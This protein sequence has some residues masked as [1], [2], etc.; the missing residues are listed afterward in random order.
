[1]DNVNLFLLAQQ[2]LFGIKIL[3]LVFAKIIKRTLLMDNV[4]NVI[5]TKFGIKINV[6]ANL[7]FLKLME[8]VLPVI[9]TQHIMAKTVFVI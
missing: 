4:K 3:F 1:M 9:H 5:K 6:N 8:I 7:N 2:D